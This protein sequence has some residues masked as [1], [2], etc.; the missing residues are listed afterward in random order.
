MYIDNVSDYLN[1]IKAFGHEEA[2][3]SVS[4]HSD[5]VFAYR[6]LNDSENKLIPGIYR[7]MRQEGYSSENK[8]RAGEKAVLRHFIQ[9]ASIYHDQFPSDDRYHWVQLAQHYGVPTRLLDWSNNPLVSL[10]FAC[11]RHENRDGVVWILHKNRYHKFSIETEKKKEGIS[12]QMMLSGILGD[13]PFDETPKYPFLFAPYYFDQRMTAQAS[14]FMA[15]GSNTDC[16]EE[17]L[18]D[19]I[20]VLPDQPITDILDREIRTHEILD[21]YVKKECLAPIY[22]KGEHKDLIIEE[23]NNLGINEK[24]LFPGIEGVGKYIEH[25]YNQDAR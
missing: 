11:E 24:T 22:I 21:N 15:W 4:W 13:Q 20:M 7:K 8:Y 12:P 17:M 23:L 1:V 9:E 25:R 14:W 16:L 3:G 5:S 10:F 2:N 18:K 6:G 19:R